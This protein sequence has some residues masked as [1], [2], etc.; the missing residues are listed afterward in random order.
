MFIDPDEKYFDNSD[1]SSLKQDLHMNFDA[2]VEE[3]VE[4]TILKAVRKDERIKRIV[5]LNYRFDDK[6]YT[7]YIDVAAEL[8]LVVNQNG[9]RE[10]DFTLVVKRD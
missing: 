7:L 8:N 6:N 10:I 5:N 1:Y 3:F 4:E 2:V 9:D